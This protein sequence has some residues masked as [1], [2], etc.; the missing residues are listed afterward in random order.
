MTICKFVGRLYIATRE[1]IR[2]WRSGGD[3]ATYLAK[4]N[5]RA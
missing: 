2:Y 4:V 5:K 3:V 1:A